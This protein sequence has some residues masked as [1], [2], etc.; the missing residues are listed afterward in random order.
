MPERIQQ[1]LTRGWRKPEGA[2][3]VSRPSSWGNPF[4]IGETKW[5]ADAEGN[6]TLFPVPDAA[7][8]VRLFRWY[9]TGGERE[10]IIRKQLA[11]KDLACWCPLDQPCHAD[12]LLE[13]ANRPTIQQVRTSD[14]GEK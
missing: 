9:V 7:E 1:R 11:G 13:I 3:I 5:L 6:P 12:V 4:K 2:V 8:A 10:Q 14:Q